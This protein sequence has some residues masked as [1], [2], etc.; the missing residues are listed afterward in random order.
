MKTKPGKT[1]DEQIE[2]LKSRR[3]VV[4][5]D[6]DVAETL[7][8]LNYYVLSGYL[9]GFKDQYGNY[10]DGLT[11]ERIH[12]LYK[13]DSALRNILLYAMERIEQ[14]LK[15]RV[16]YM[17]AL[18]YPD[19]PCIYESA[20]LFKNGDEHARFMKGFHTT[21]RHYAEVPFVKHHINKYDGHFPIW[22]AVELFTMGNLRH[23]YLNLPNTLR[24]RISSSFNIPPDVMDSWLENLR[25]TR[26]SLAHNM[27]LYGT[28]IQLTPKL[29][30][31]Y[32]KKEIIRNRIFDQIRLMMVL[33]PERENWIRIINDIGALLDDY[34]DVI[35]LGKIGFPKNWIDYLEQRG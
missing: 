21:V 4:E 15:T 26:N 20:S 10:E 22:V 13:F 11:F 24:R 18:A 29:P 9:H 14:L 1:I 27:R 23:L 28:T 31:Q 17:I 7:S 3:L 30:R 33:Y 35:E 6:T 8:T 2:I 5:N 12:S 25:I 34:K 32:Y 19:D 16:A